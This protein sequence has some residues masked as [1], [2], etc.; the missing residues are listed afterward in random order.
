[1]RVSPLTLGRTARETRF[2]VDVTDPFILVQNKISLCRQGMS[3]A[4]PPNQLIEKLYKNAEHVK[5]KKKYC[6]NDATSYKCIENDITCTQIT[7][8]RRLINKYGDRTLKSNVVRSEIAYKF[9]PER[10]TSTI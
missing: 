7:H 4:L 5:E 1:M 2:P 3:I 8:V 10:V 6:L 9:N